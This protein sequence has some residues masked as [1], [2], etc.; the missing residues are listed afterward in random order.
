MQW[1]LIPLIH[2][3]TCLFYLNKLPVVT[4]HYLLEYKL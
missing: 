3:L 2:R 4:V 1:L